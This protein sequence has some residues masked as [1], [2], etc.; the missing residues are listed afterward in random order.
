MPSVLKN[1]KP[2]LLSFIAAVLMATAVLFMLA[3]SHETNKAMTEAGE[4]AATGLLDAIMLDIATQHSEL[5]FFQQY[6]LDR[7]KRRLMDVAGIVADL[8]GYYYSE[9]SIGVLPFG[10]A[11]TSLL[12]AAKKLRY[13]HN[14][15][16]FIYD[17]RN[18]CI[19][20]PSPGMIGRDMSDFLDKQGRPLIPLAWAATQSGEG[21]FD[22]I[23]FPRLGEEKD[24]SKLVYFKRVEG[25]D[26][27]LGA[28][29]YIDDIARDVE[30]K[31]KEVV[32][33]LQNTLEG[34][35][36][37]KTGNLWLFTGKGEVL[38]HPK[39]SG[40]PGDSEQDKRAESTVNNFIQAA[41]GDGVLHYNWDSPE[42]PGHFVHPKVAWVRHF[43]PMDWYLTAAV[44]KEEL[45][46]PAK[47]T[48]RRQSLFLVGILVLSLGAGWLFAS[49]VTTPLSRLSRHAQNLAANDFTSPAGAAEVLPDLTFPNEIKSLASTIGEMESKLADYLSRLTETT[50]AKERIQS[51]LRIAHR[52][53]MDM[54]P[55]PPPRIAPWT[56]LDLF[57][58]LTPAKEV[59][60]DLFDYFTVGDEL[61]C[62]LVGDVSGKGVPAALF[63]A[64]CK[65]LAR[66]F[67][68]RGLDP[69]EILSRVD[70]ELS[71]GN[72]ECMFVTLFLGVLDPKTGELAFC[73]AGHNPPYLIGPEG[74]CRA[75]T[76]Q[77]NLPLG[78]DMGA[79]FATVRMKLAVG[80]SL[81]I[82]TDGV[83]EAQ[84]EAKELF[85]ATRLEAV[86]TTCA[87]FPAKT[88]AETVFEAVETFE[89]GAERADDITI[90]AVR[91]LGEE[92]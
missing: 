62:L 13:G 15:Y 24:E 65:A 33:D 38:A 43:A 11:R 25:F 64:Q 89:A 35:R 91:F 20:H 12:E 14:D 48:L 53:Q 92:S 73:N 47:A 88:L 54:L 50:M 32:A 29:V 26:F 80:E 19:S 60:G 18:V 70:G 36:I 42:D 69:G 67:A 78:L 9:S 63:M 46:A 41:H 68:Q 84:T 45:T 66:G 90:L 57:A 31:K 2:V 5:V 71:L 40:K 81:V 17:R 39:L 30:R 21:Y 77:P 76:A 27:L 56:A 59:G 79:A 10:V 61:V 34:I 23:A 58:L 55:P 37:A 51:E 44:Y 74:F 86:L 49:K 52:I 72:A 87:G 3:A 75:V 82:Y 83:T 16:F 4:Q 22:L 8:A 28:G 1:F 7:Y 6:S 85:S